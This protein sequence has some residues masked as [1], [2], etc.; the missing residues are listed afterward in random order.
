MKINPSE[1]PREACDENLVVLV[2]L[3]SSVTLFLCSSQK[4]ASRNGNSCY[5]PR[6]T[7]GISIS[8]LSQYDSQVSSSVVSSLERT[9]D[10]LCVIP[11]PNT[12]MFLGRDVKAGNILLTEPGLVKLGDFGSASIVAPANSFVGTPYW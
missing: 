12:V 6:C 5:Y 11:S 8:S 9:A 2:S 3:L 1:S 4:A 7:A 10:V